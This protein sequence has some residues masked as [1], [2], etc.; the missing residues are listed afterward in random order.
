M[1]NLSVVLASETDA[2]SKPWLLNSSDLLSIVGSV[3]NYKD[4]ENGSEDV[5]TLRVQPVISYPKYIPSY[6]TAHNTNEDTQKGKFK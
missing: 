5:S 3:E 6:V 1:K 2:M 4:T